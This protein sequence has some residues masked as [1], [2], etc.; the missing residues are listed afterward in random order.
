MLQITRNALNAANCNV[1]VFY[2]EGY[3]CTFSNP[4]A[5][6]IT[7]HTDLEVY[8]SEYEKVIIA[9]NLNTY[10]AVTKYFTIYF[11]IEK[12]L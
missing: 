4:K 7:S 6:V 8:L 10:F 9:A 12:L 1:R 2:I 5:R 11:F 3:G